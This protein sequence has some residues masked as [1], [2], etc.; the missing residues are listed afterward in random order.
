MLKKYF[1]I[2]KNKAKARFLSADLDAMIE[3]A[4]KIVKS[5][6][7]CERHCGIDRS[8]ELGFCK[9]PNKILISSEFL[10]YGEEYFFV[11]SHTIFF[12]GC[13]FRCAYCQNW[14]ISN[15]FEQGF[16]ATPKELALIIKMRKR[17]GSKNVNFVG[18]EPTPYLLFILKILDFLKKDNVNIPIV[19]NSNF[20]MSKKTMNILNKVI[21]VYLPDFK[22]GNDACAKKLSSVDRY[23]ETVTRNLLLS[24]GEICIRHLVLP[25]HIKCCSFP[26]LEWIAKNIGER[27]IINIMDQY[28]PCFKANEYEEINRRLTSEEFEK[29]T[30]YARRLGLNLI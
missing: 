9:A 7:L 19:W 17:E 29:V 20:Y 23:W 14:T 25:N 11:P 1:E 5:C 16:E 8:K 12:M 4:K 30:N 10:H 3:E 27:A 15:W 26:V 22:Y 2:L 6:S 18:G 21:D 24:E 13:N 28:H